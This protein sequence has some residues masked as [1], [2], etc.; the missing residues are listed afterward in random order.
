MPSN[1]YLH[2]KTRI[3]K[4]KLRKEIDALCYAGSVFMP[5][6][7]TPQIYQLYV[8]QNAGGL[9]IAMWILYSIGVI[10]F[11]LFGIIH[12]EKQLIIL[13]ILWLIANSLMI[14]GILLYR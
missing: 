10:P 13:N 4:E 14:I 8:T 1:Q 3:N 9:S 7:A 6:T 11:L 5:L 2:H 12:K